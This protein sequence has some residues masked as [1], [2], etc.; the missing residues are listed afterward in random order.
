MFYK[1]V[2]RSTKTFYGV[3]FKPGEIKEVPKYIN[4]RFMVVVS[5]PKAE[6][7]KV[8]QPAQPKLNKKSAHV[9]EPASSELTDKPDKEEKLDG[10]DSN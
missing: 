8:E 6:P 1:N 7:A 10:T 3:E 5:E 2:S 9:E 4:H